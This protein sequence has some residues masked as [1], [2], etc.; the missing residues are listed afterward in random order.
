MADGRLLQKQQVHTTA[1]ICLIATNFSP[2]STLAFRALSA[3]KA[4]NKESKTWVGCLT[5]KLVTN[6]F[7]AT[8]QNPA[9]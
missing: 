2:L 9:S 1:T 4:L 7:S 3:V 5:R 6:H 8:A